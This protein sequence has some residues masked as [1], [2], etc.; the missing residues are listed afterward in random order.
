MSRLLIFDRNFQCRLDRT[1]RPASVSPPSSS[2]EGLSEEES[3]QLIMGMCYSLKTM[4]GKLAKSPGP[5]T[6]FSYRTPAYRLH[7]YEVASGWRF[8][9]LIAGPSTVRSCVW[10]GHTVTL[11]SALAVFYREIFLEWVLRNPLLEDPVN[12]GGGNTGHLDE[13]VGGVGAK[14]AEF[15]QLP[16]FG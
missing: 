8:V 12:I 2:P 3:M 11:E 13:T 16:I 1:S 15:M 14:I 10:A 5:D 7:Y 4:L 6:I 9:L